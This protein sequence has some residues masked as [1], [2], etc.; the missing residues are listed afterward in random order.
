MT[1]PQH[2]DS[3]RAILDSVFAAP[4]YKWVQRPDH[5]SWIRHAWLAIKDWYANL[6]ETHPLGY[7]VAMYAALALTVAI[8]LH[9]AWRFFADVR[10]VDAIHPGPD[11]PAFRRDE[12]WYRREADRLAASGRYPEAM[13][14][15]FVALVLALDARHALRFHPSKTPGEYARESTFAPEAR[16]AFRDLVRR[17][18]T[19]AFARVPCGAAE[20]AEW[21]SDTSVERYAPAN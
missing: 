19:Y 12:A 7:Q 15:D 5:V 21:R 9:A 1:G 20:F 2:P 13:Q 6:R 3:L 4:A 17:L 8:V 16:A 18:Y 14:A 10:S 11:A